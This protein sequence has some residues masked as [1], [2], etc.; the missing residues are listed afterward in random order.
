MRGGMTILDLRTLLL[1][2]VL[3]SLGCA[4]L[5][6][7][8]SRVSNRRGTLSA[9]AWAEGMLGIG[10]ALVALRGVTPD[11][12]TYVIANLLIVAGYGGH[13]LSVRRLVGQ[14]F[15][16]G[17]AL[18][19]L[20]AVGGVQIWLTY[21]LP[22]LPG[23]I[24][25]IS[26]VCAGIAVL[27]VVDAVRCRAVARM[28]IVP[29]GVFAAMMLSRGF[30][31]V[32]MPDPVIQPFLSSGPVQ[33]GYFLGFLLIQLWMAQTMLWSIGMDW[34]REVAGA[35]AARVQAEE[36]HLT[37]ETR[38][39]GLMALENACIVFLDAEVRVVEASPSFCRLLGVGSSRD[40]VGKTL[41]P[42]TAEEDRERVSL[43]HRA[44]L[45]GQI[46]S[47]RVRKSLRT[48]QETQVR[49]DLT[50]GPLPG[51]ALSAGH[52]GGFVAFCLP[53]TEAEELC[54]PA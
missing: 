33:Q 38:L 44:L 28:L 49:V 18:P 20:A 11:I 13:W 39:S 40:L 21:F 2:L 7:V 22:S 42:Y 41:L 9:L 31:A 30:L 26:L 8:L 43:L 48:G 29:H 15:P 37:S 1:V 6:M 19:V 23:R 4:A 12:V 34:Y 54:V 51:Q 35:V 45:D 10:F 3:V 14:P 24:I 52:R 32:M 36:R 25:L 16:W 53:L 46:G 47:Y 5:C 27:I 50:L 17:W